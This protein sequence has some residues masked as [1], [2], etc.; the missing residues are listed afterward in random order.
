ML[1][2][3]YIAGSEII[4]RI[5]IWMAGEMVGSRERSIGATGALGPAGPNVQVSQSE[6]KPKTQEDQ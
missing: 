6:T 2:W 5:E 4:E 3:E 1:R